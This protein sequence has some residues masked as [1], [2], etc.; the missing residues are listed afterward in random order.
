MLVE[1]PPHH[2]ISGGNSRHL[3]GFFVAGCRLFL[4]GTWL[5]ANYLY[6]CADPLRLVALPRAELGRAEPPGWEDASSRRVERGSRLVIA[7]PKHSRYIPKMEDICAKCKLKV[8]KK[9]ISCI[10]SYPDPTCQI[11]KEEI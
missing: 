11:D 3:R 4:A 10:L 1:G 7:V 2:S 5:W 6:R 8:T 9:K